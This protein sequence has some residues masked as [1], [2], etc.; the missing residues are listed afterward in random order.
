MTFDD[1]T[2]RRRTTAALV[3]LAATTPGGAAAPGLRSRDGRAEA[4]WGIRRRAQTLDDVSPT[5][6]GEGGRPR[7]GCGPYV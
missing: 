1:T 6:W 4:H 7:R 2:K 3:V 5:R